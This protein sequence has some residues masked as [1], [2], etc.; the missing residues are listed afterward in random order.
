MVLWLFMIMALENS[1]SF[2]RGKVSI[3]Y[4]RPI[5][6]PRFEVRHIAPHIALTTFVYVGLLRVRSF[7]TE[8]HAAAQIRP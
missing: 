2:F 7:G 8:S 5:S 4:N 3:S 6:V 1:S